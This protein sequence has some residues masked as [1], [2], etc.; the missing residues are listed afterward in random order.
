MILVSGGT[1]LVGSRVVSLLLEQEQSI[2]VL[3]RG[4]SD[5]KGS[6]M[7][8]FR[9]QGVDVVVGDLQDRNF[10]EKAMDGCKVVINTSGSISS[11]VGKNKDGVAT[12]LTNIGNLIDSARRASVQ[13]FVH[14]SCL[15]A[16]EHS[17]SRYFFAKWQ[18][19]QVVKQGGYYWT[20]F[21]PSL[22]FAN[23]SK[24]MDALGFL[25]KL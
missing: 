10:V 22:I 23:P 6:V 19:E 7:P 1:G 5:W 16:T 21:R 9:N 12:P 8:Q 13:R 20:I 18:E 3:A 25:V 2:R 15:G 24:F 11:F 4:L 17:T 14:L